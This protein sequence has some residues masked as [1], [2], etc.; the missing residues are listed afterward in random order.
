MAI[1][2]P[3]NF[4]LKDSLEVTLR[5]YCP[6][7]ETTSQIFARVVA[8]ETQ[9]TLKYDGMPDIPLDRLTASFTDYADH[10]VNLFIGVFLGEEVIANLRF[11]QRR[12]D[13]PWIKHIGTFGMAVKEQ[14]WGQGIG[15]RLLQAMEAHAR[16]TEI[17]RI[18][19]EVR[20]SND[21]GIS[22]YLKN[23]F[24]IE[25]TREKAAFLNGIFEDEL[26]IA[27]CL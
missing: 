25:G 11:M 10:P 1:I 6:G 16:T 9:N 21:S 18:E 3:Q 20:A 23:G 22:L 2:I 13:H 7:D 14:Y 15:S 5:S 4:N 17:S 12:P 8:K 26:S 24:K 19:A 27:K